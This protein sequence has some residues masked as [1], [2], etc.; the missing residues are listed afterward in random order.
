LN[1]K[2]RN[3][4]AFTPKRAYYPSQDPKVGGAKSETAFKMGGTNTPGSSGG[5]SSSGSPGA[6]SF[7]PTAVT[8]KPVTLQPTAAHTASSQTP[9][10]GTVGVNPPASTGAS[11]GATSDSTQQSATTATPSTDSYVNNANQIAQQQYDSSQAAYQAQQTA[12][13]YYPSAYRRGT[14]GALVNSYVDQADQM[15]QQQYNASQAAAYQAEHGYYPSAY[16]GSGSQTGVQVGDWVS[17]GV[18][19]L[20][21]SAYYNGSR[22]QTNRQPTATQ[23][24]PA[25]ATQTPPRSS[26]QQAAAA[27]AAAQQA[28]QQAQQRAIQNILLSIPH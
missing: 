20:T 2:V 11:S 1:R 9:E 21:R 8:T 28:A 13:G 15:A 25:A 24:Q 23:R 26:A 27:Q 10:F 7:K 18:N 19:G 4:E 5:A 6:G 22:S 3:Q 16:N 12:A 17:D 14:N